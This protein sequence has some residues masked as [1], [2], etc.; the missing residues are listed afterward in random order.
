MYRVYD[1][2]MGSHSAFLEASIANKHSSHYGS[3]FHSLSHELVNHR[4]TIE[5]VQEN[6]CFLKWKHGEVSKQEL[7]RSA[8]GIFERQPERLSRVRLPSLAAM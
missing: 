3:P 2:H 7:S 4:R 8:R 1:A 5:H 6:A